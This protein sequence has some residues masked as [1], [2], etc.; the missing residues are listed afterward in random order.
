MNDRF[1][2]SPYFLDEYRPAVAALAAHDWRVVQTELL[3]GEPTARMGALY[4]SL[5]TDVR[6]ALDAGE[7]PVTF[8]GDCCATLGVMAG[9]QQA[10]LQATLIWLDAHGD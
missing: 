8:A 10:G 7:R 2:L 3:P 5:A 6:T 1:I 4:H 9:L